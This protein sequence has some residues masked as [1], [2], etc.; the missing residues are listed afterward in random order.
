MLKDQKFRDKIKS[1]YAKEKNIKLL[2]I[3]YWEFDNI[4]K[5]LKKE[6]EEK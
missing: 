4:E 5:M 6:L 2:R 1:N 3:P